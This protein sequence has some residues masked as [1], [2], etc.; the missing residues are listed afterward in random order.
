MDNLIV[1]IGNTR[2]KIAV[3]RGIETLCDGS[4]D[5]F[6]GEAIRCVEAF[7]ERYGVK[8]SILSSTRGDGESVK[9]KLSR[10][11][12][13][14]LLFNHSTPIPIE[15]SYRSPN[16]LGS[17]RLAAAIGAWSLYGEASEDIDRLL[18]VD[19]GSA[20]TI[21]LVTRS[22]GFEGGVISP[23]VA[24]R[25]R[26]LHEFTAKLPLCS[27]TNETLDVARTTV[28]AIE[29]G[30]MEGITYEIEG[31][32]EKNRAKDAKIVV[33]FAGGDAKK[34]ENRIKNTI[35]AKCEL[36]MV[37]LNRI[38]EYNAKYNR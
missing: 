15:N 30:V 5:A 17:D 4:F 3:I 37:G 12:E 7:V 6:D 29:Q 13:S 23:G 9:E 18:I 28:E 22:G 16:T 32:I 2:I 31:H 1:D 35:F 33:V 34:F 20:I 36:V 14:V 26:A 10:I 11:V 21:D 8:H 27:P 38:L 24:M 25:F 19:L